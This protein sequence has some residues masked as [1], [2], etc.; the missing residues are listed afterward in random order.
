MSSSHP[1]TNTLTPEGNSVRAN[2]TYTSFWHV[3]GCRLWEFGWRKALGLLLKVP[4]RIARTL[5][6]CRLGSKLPPFLTAEPSFLSHGSP[7]S[8]TELQNE[9]TGTGVFPQLRLGHTQGH[10]RKTSQ[11]SSQFYYPLSTLPQEQARVHTLLL[12]ELVF[13]LLA[14]PKSPPVRLTSLP[15]SQGGLS[16]PFRTPGLGCP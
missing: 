9:E 11:R 15:V 7:G 1:S 6:R 5:L 2:S 4:V 12:N 10:L 16:F 8:S 14:V 3:M 13:L